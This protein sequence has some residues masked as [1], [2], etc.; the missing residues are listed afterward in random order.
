MYID[1]LMES[2]AKVESNKKHHSISASYALHTHPC[3]RFRIQKTL[4]VRPLKPIVNSG[5]RKIFPSHLSEVKLII[6]YSTIHPLYLYLYLYLYLRHPHYIVSLLLFL[7][8]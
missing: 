3:F 8:I 6:I 1:H 4:H 5:P 2:E 7:Y